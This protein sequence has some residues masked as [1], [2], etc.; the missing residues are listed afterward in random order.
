MIP[1]FCLDDGKQYWF[2]ASTPYEAMQK[3]KYT[4]DLSHTDKDAVIS[5]TESGMHLYMDHGGKTYIVRT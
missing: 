1:V 3:M 5:K 4:L 2:T